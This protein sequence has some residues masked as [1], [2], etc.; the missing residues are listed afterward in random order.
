[1]T[2]PVT[3]RLPCGEPR[4]DGTP[5][6]SLI[7]WRL[8]D[9]RCIAH[10]PDAKA[11]KIAA[12][13]RGGQ[14]HAEKER[15]VLPG[16]APENIPV[17]DWSTPRALLAW[18]ES[19]AALVE[20]GLLDTRN[21]PAELARVARAVHEVEQLAELKDALLRL[22]KGGSVVTLLAQLRAGDGVRRPLPW[23]NPRLISGPP[24]EGGA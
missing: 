21:I 23:K 17:L 1:M 2:A 12:V 24:A 6:P 5:C 8:P 9:R 15:R 20:K 11:A 18:C 10:H 16:Q 13:H 19:R 3:P 4:K 7:P 14:R 22:E